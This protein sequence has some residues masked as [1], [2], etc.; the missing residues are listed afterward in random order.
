MPYTSIYLLEYTKNTQM[1]LIIKPH[2]FSF[3]TFILSFDLCCSSSSFF[4][5]NKP[6]VF[7]RYTH[8]QDLRAQLAAASSVQTVNVDDFG[9]KGDGR[10]DDTLVDIYI[11]IYISFCIP[12]MFL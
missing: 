2:L 4:P 11:Y 9:A 6:L 7:H 3:F 10:T 8:H 12:S 1:A 5:Y